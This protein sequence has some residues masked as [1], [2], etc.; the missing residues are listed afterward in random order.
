MRTK[1]VSA[2]CFTVLL[3]ILWCLPAAAQRI[4]PSV[5]T[6]WG[7]VGLG[8]SNLG[9]ISGY[10]SASLQTSAYMLSGRATANSEQL[11]GGDEYYDAAILFSYATRRERYHLSIGTGFG[12]LWGSRGHGLFSG[13]P[14]TPID[15]IWGLAAE[16]Q[17]FW[18]PARW[19]GV[20]GYGYLNLNAVQTIGGG[21]IGVQFGEM[22]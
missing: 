11:L 12:V 10:V 3:A 18:R 19:F 4:R 13:T 16:A 5:L 22:W 6:W 21:G 1:T 8:S 20:G 7:T 17:A 15:A 2:A 9:S 14:R